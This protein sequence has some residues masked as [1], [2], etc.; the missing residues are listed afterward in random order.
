[1]KTGDGRF[2]NVGHYAAR[3]HYGPGHIGER[4][5][6][7]KYDGMKTKQTLCFADVHVVADVKIG[8]RVHCTSFLCAGRKILG[9][10]SAS[11][12]VH[13]KAKVSLHIRGELRT[14]Q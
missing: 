7:T 11:S 5:G 8:K 2:A 10:G 3:V 4:G 1:M 12:R 6:G 14:W 9:S 13:C